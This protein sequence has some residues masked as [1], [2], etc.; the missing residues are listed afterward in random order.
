MLVKRMHE[1]DNAAEKLYRVR[2]RSPHPRRVLVARLLWSMVQNTLYRYSFHTSHRWRA[3]LLRLFGAKIGHR[4]V[5]RRTSRIYYPWNLTMGDVSALGDDV[6]M[7]TLGPVTL[8]DRVNI[9]QEAYICTG[10]HDYRLRSMPLVTAPITIKD[11]VWI[12]ARAFVGPGVTVG[13]ASIV[14]AGAIVVRDV[15]DWTI[16][17]G[18]P[19][20]VISPRPQFADEEGQAGEQ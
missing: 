20:R 8:G 13:E 9:S 15:P 3:F 14:A 12:C 5:F 16:V 7:Y 4:C 2:G 11:D 10:T 18:N 6:V 19:A 1:N 17:G